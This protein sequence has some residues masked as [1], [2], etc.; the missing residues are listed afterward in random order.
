MLSPKKGNIFSQHLLQDHVFVE[1]SILYMSFGNSLLHFWCTQWVQIEHSILQLYKTAFWQ[2][3][4]SK[5]VDW[6]FLAHFL[7]F[8]AL[9]FMHTLTHV[10][11]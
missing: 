9:Q 2:I 5:K 8:L 10:F 3:L 4:Q 1:F 6:Y 7:T 11:L